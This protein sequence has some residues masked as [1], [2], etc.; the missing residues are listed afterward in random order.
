MERLTRVQAL[1]EQHTREAIA[2]LCVA[3]TDSDGAVRHAAG[4]A[5]ARL[6]GP[7]VVETLLALLRHRIS[8]PA[9]LEAVRILG[10]LRDARARPVLE[11]LAAKAQDAELGAAARAAVDRIPKP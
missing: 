5:L 7:H 1:S 6:G 8:K 9:A 4:A 10:Q 11:A 2:E 3:L